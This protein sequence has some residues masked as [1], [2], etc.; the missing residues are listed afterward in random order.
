MGR[1]L[2]GRIRVVESDNA[3]SL[4]DVCMSHCSCYPKNSKIISALDAVHAFC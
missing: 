2:H 1:P 4:D 3:A